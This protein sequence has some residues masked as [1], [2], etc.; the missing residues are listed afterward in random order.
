MEYLVNLVSREGAVVLDPFAGSGT[1]GMACLRK[2]RKHILIE[3]EQ[4]YYDIIMK[5][6][7]SCK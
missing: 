2:N 5:R 1:T 6:L 3:R 7:E 4:E